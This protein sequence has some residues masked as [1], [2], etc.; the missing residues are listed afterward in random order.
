MRLTRDPAFAREFVLRRADRLLF[1]SDYLMPGQQ[2]PQFEILSAMNLPDEVEYKIHR[3][4]AIRIL[5]LAG[6]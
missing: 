4:N 2:I 6:K 1:G 3:G 5:K